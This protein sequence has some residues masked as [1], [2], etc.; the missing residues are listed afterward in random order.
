MINVAVIGFGM[1][2]K[3]FHLPLISDNEEFQ[4]TAICTSQKQLVSEKYPA[5]SIYSSIDELIK[6]SEVDLV[7]ITTPNA[8]HYNHTKLCLEN[9]VHVI[10]EKPMTATSV[11]AEELVKLAEA[12]KLILSVFHN[13]RWD[14]DFLTV[15]KLLSNNA[16]G[17]I[18]LFESNFDRF[19][20]IVSDKWKE[21]PGPATGVW[22]DL[23]AH[24][25]DQIICL[26]GLPVSLTARCLA[27]RDD[28][29]TTDYFHVQLH[30]PELEVILHS[31]PYTVV[32]NSRFNI[33]GSKRCLVKHGL[34]IQ[35]EQL[36]NGMLP[37]QKMFGEDKPE[38]HATLYSNTSENGTTSENIVTEHG[39]YKQFYCGIAHAINHGEKVPVSGD[40][41]VN[42]IKILELAVQS[43]KSGQTLILE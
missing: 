32:Q 37:S 8:L 12:N 39:D 24:L 15:K 4:L 34:D 2:A 14:G 21:H 10:V 36:K 9:D 43:S 11:E 30:Y 19:R 25:V 26:F 40:D 17:E 35:E 29:K 3:V 28:S 31:S 41:G 33:Q 5:I 1:S 6:H 42:V 27:L 16:L 7:I 18:R 22:F 20:P 23:G 13:R 38:Y